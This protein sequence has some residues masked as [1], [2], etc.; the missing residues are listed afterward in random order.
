MTY[1]TR[2][3]DDHGVVAEL[4]AF[5][6]EG[7][8]EY[9][10][11]LHVEPRGELFAGQ[12]ARLCAAAAELTGTLNGA[13]PVLKRYF[14][15]DAANQARLIPAD[16]TCA[17]SIIQQTPL[18]GSKVAMWV[19][20]TAPSPNSHSSL[21]PSL[22][23]SKLPSE[24][25]HPSPVREGEDTLANEESI[26]C[27]VISPSLPG[28]GWQGGV[29]SPD[30]ERPGGYDVP[31]RAERAL[32]HTCLTSP[33]GDSAQQ[34][35]SI[36]R[37]Y[38]NALRT[39]GGTLAD[40]CIRTWFY[41]R[42]VDTQYAGMVSARRENFAEQGLTPAT[43]YLASTGIQGI[44]ASPRA[45]IQMDAY[46]V[47]GLKPG[48]QHHLKALSHLNPTIEYG[49]TFERA[50]VV[51]YG[52]RSHCF[53]SGTASID[54]KGEVLHPGD[55]V[56]QTRRMWENVEALLAE[57]QFTAQDM[58]QAIVYLRDAADYATVRQLFAEHYPTLPLVITHAPVCRPGWLIEME[59]IA[60][61]ER[62]NPRYDAF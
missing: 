16:A 8:S 42:D 39:Q 15:S 9:H 19:Y 10:A 5:C 23:P 62:K 54:N 53:I 60:I 49:V 51:D 44:P 2:K 36:L 45:I 61:A 55:I 22:S 7:K 20:L 35:A 11:M 50:T 30:G 28:E 58:A 46:A 26:S 48:Q 21:T 13:R 34:T 27:N 3:W 41:V 56:S 24:L 1:T 14:L 29:G 12:F 52:D 6:T 40:N 18:D 47:L 38:E 4:S 32:W 31:A 37:S 17:V 43:H 25:C 57:G 59:C 33:S